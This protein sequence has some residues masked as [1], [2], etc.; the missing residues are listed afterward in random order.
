MKKQKRWIEV[1]IEENY[2][3][4]E[5]NPKKRVPI[6]QGKINLD[7]KKKKMI[8]QFQV[9]ETKPFDELCKCGHRKGIHTLVGYCKHCKKECW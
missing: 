9:K 7:F 5:D 3:I 8:I 1:N 6:S 4:F 2:V